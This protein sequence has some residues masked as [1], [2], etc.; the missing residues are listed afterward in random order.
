MSDDF[1][2]YLDYL[3]DCINGLNSGK[4][5]ILTDG[6][7]SASSLIVIDNFGKIK[8]GKCIPEWVFRLD[9]PHKGC[10]YSHLNIN[11]KMF[12]IPDPHTPIPDWMVKYGKTFGKGAKVAGKLFSIVGI[13]ADIYNVCKSV[14]KD[15]RENGSVESAVATGAKT[16]APVV[17][18]RMACP[19][20][21][22]AGAVIG[23]AILPG[24]GTV[25]G[26]I[27]GS[28]LATFAADEIVHK[29]VH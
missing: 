13:V 12:G 4:Y 27:C 25:V 15:Y 24:V 14:V 1:P 3:T 6:N 7:Y 28:L 16:A 20:G 17:G 22:S 11:S 5:R 10:N 19:A 18:S 2:E 29:S 26:S 23:T 8:N 21:A 9:K